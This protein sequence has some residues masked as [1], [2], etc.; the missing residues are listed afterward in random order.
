MQT[1]W[2]NSETFLEDVFVPAVDEISVMRKYSEI[3]KKFKQLEGER[4]LTP[5]VTQDFIDTYREA[6]EYENFIRSVPGSHSQSY[7]IEKVLAFVH[8]GDN[9]AAAS[10]FDVPLLRSA[11]DP[12]LQTP[13]SDEPNRQPKGQ[14]DFDTIGLPR[15]NPPRQQSPTRATKQPSFRNR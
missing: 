8:S 15:E 2:W 12:F 13:T 11:C 5:K 4:R 1:D 14:G 10:A 3:A 6:S 7:I 9:R